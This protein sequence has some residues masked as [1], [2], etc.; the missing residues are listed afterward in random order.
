VAG[1]WGNLIPE[2][3]RNQLMQD[4]RSEL[5][6]FW[7]IFGRGGDGGL[8]LMVVATLEVAISIRNH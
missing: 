7:L 8:S 5:R 6:G 4:F 3:W 1:K 2:L